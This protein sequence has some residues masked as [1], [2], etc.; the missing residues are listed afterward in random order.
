MIMFKSLVIMNEFYDCMFNI[1]YFSYEYIKVIS[2]YIINKIYIEYIRKK[3][4]ED[5]Y[6]RIEVCIYK[7]NISIIKE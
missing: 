6:F 1:F 2:V 4:K 5:F 7:N 3:D